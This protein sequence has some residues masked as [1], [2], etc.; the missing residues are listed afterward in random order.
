MIIQ[1]KKKNLEIGI[2]QK[3]LYEELRKECIRDTFLKYIDDENFEV[4]TYE[5]KNNVPDYSILA[6]NNNQPG[7]KENYSGVVYEHIN[8]IEAF[9]KFLGKEIIPHQYEYCADFSP[10]G[11]I[12]KKLSLKRPNNIDDN[13]CIGNRNCEVIERIAQIKNDLSIVKRHIISKK[14]KTMLVSEKGLYPFEIFSNFLHLQR[15][16]GDVIKYGECL[17]THFSEH[18]KYY[19]YING[20]FAK[21]CEKINIFEIIRMLKAE[22]KNKKAHILRYKNV[23]LFLQNGLCN[24][25]AEVEKMV[26]V[27]DRFICDTCLGERQTGQKESIASVLLPVF[28]FVNICLNENMFRRIMNYIFLTKLEMKKCREYLESENLM[29]TLHT[30]YAHVNPITNME[31]YNDLPSFFEKTFR[32][33]LSKDSESLLMLYKKLVECQV[34]VDLIS[35]EA[36]KISNTIENMCKQVERITRIIRSIH[37]RWVKPLEKG[38]DPTR[39]NTLTRLR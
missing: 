12:I 3:E 36:Q 8:T 9:K 38:Q 35:R 5:G 10:E 6:G 27:C 22:E 16:L 4:Y 14:D 7:D 33:Y 29:K 25:F 11:D 15:K 13:Y 26:D 23:R 28:F 19:K 2:F 24:T 17:D 21:R 39:D 37:H 20:F 30:F 32:I 1:E 31:N 34:G 18:A